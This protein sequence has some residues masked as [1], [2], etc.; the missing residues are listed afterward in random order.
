MGTQ[1]VAK[2]HSS[3]Q[4]PKADTVQS[5]V[6]ITSA[7]Q[8]RKRGA[9]AGLASPTVRKTNRVEIKP[10]SN[11]KN[12][13]KIF[14]GNGEL[15]VCRE[16]AK[17][18]Q[19]CTTSSLS[20]PD[21]P[22][23]HTAEDASCSTHVEDHADASPPQHLPSTSSSKKQAP[24]H[25]ADAA[26][27]E[28]ELMAENVPEA[29]L[30]LSSGDNNAT[31]SMS[32]GASTEAT[33]P[34][35]TSPTSIAVSAA[36][37]Y[38]RMSAGKDEDSDSEYGLEFNP[39]SFVRTLPPLSEVL[40]LH[41]KLLL[42]PQTRRFSRKTLVLDLDETLVHSTLDSNE[43]ADFNFTVA[44]NGREHSVAVRQRPFLFE[45]LERVAQLYEVVVFTASQKV[46][47]EQL[48]NILDPK[49]RLIRH[50]VFRDDCVIVSGNYLKSLTVLGRDLSQTLII[51]NSPQ[52]FGFQLS[53]GIPIESWY[54]DES[55]TE[56]QQL[57]PFLEH[58]VGVPDVRVDIEKRY[59]LHKEVEKAPKQL[60]QF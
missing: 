48:L 13:A 49:R 18:Q 21:T 40:P 10:S 26:M 52:A 50:R 7:T 42:P 31:S 57:L 35:L 60:F 28:S 23:P 43:A 22:H 59:Q 38:N 2:N 53:N 1:S 19:T 17:D 9:D 24:P 27:A 39:Y 8:K 11:P 55:D 32:M 54:D 41:H 45:F 44:F 46:Y 30:R 25:S 16:D 33:D 58:L 37:A 3:P 51:D 5:N 6:L 4:S 36:D 20:R 14:L 56:L 12:L 34:A 47:A 29:V 15:L